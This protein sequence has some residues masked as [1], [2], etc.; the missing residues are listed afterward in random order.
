MSYILSARAADVPLDKVDALSERELAVLLQRICVVCMWH[1]WHVMLTVIDT[2]NFL[3]WWTRASNA[4]CLIAICLRR[5]SSSST[6]RLSPISQR[7]T[8]TSVLGHFGLFSRAG[9]TRTEVKQDRSGC[10]FG[11][12]DRNNQN[13]SVPKTEVDVLCQIWSKS[14]HI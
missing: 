4:R 1:H 12:K 8:S 14:A 10:L 9:V 11:L 6:R 2:V 5:S 7:I 3:W 13:R